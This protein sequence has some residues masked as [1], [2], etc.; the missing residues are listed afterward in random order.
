MP[1]NGGTAHDGNGLADAVTVTVPLRITVR[2]GNGSSRAPAVG[3][4]LS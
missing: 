3:V 4:N 2:Q 1:P